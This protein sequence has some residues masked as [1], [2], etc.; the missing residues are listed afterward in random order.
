MLRSGKRGEAESRTCEPGLRA[1]R[2]KA[3]RFGERGRWA[4]GE[5]T[6]NGAIMRRAAVS[7]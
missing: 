7:A 5:R 2:L 3:R 4:K 6:H 1:R